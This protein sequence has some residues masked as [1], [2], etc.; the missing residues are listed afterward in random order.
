MGDLWR[1]I[2]WG[3]LLVT[4]SCLVAWR[5]LETV[6][7]EVAGPQLF[8]LQPRSYSVV[9][10]GVR[11][12]VSALIVM[13]LARIISVHLRALGSDDQ[14]RRL[15]MRWT[16]VIAAVLAI[17]QAYA[18]AALLQTDAMVPPLDWFLRLALVLQLT[19]G[20]MTLVFLGELIDEA[21]LGF[22]NGV[23][24][25]YALGAVA[26]QTQ[27]LQGFASTASAYRDFSQYRPLTIWI[28]ASIVLVLA[29]V[30]VLRA[31]RAVTLVE[32]RHAVRARPLTLPLVMSGVLRPPVFASAVLS[33]PAIYSNYVARSQPAFHAWVEQNWTA[34]GTNPGW[35][36][37]YI[38]IAGGLVI[39]FAY[40]AASVDFDPVLMAS[41]LKQR[42]LRVEGRPR[43]EDAAGYLRARFR[44]LTFAGASFLALATVAIP[45]PVY[46]VTTALGAPIPLSGTDVLLV[47][48]IV[49]AIAAGI[50]HG[51][52]V[53]SRS[54]LSPA[55]AVI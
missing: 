39:F 25:I 44:R 40:F 45:V 20:T 1:R 54:D 34:Y 53:A 48:A 16:R 42:R 22:G 36:L 21:G 7:V 51:G 3:R 19:A 47:T 33:V 10:L 32:G 37:L 13:A 24:W 30:A 55:P 52:G 8:L 43:D 27:R 23:L 28:G 6:Q 41:R 50:N 18:L 35:D 5:T 2:G 14:G 31:F 17:G 12:Y 46:F 15:L 11:P 38:A 26:T 9:A 4:A 49:L 29:S